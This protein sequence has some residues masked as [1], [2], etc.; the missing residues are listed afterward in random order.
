MVTK[1]NTLMTVLTGGLI[2]SVV[3]WILLRRIDHSPTTLGLILGI[4]MG[5]VMYASLRAG[6]EDNDLGQK[7]SPWGAVI[8]FI[9][10]IGRFQVTTASAAVLGGL[11]MAGLAALDLTRMNSANA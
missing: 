4:P 3:C 9:I 5:M 6:E 10:A 2:L 11:I 7:I 8:L 1:R